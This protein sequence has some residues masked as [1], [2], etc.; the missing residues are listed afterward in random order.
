MSQGGALAQ[1]QLREPGEPG[2]GGIKCLN[3]MGNSFAFF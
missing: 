3:S 1:E 2:V